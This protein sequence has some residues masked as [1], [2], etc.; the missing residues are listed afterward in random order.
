VNRRARGVCHSRR[1]RA[2][3]IRVPQD[4]CTRVDSKHVTTWLEAFLSSR[5]HLPADPGPGDGTLCLSIPTEQWHRFIRK[6]RCSKSKALRRLL[7]A[8]LRAV[9]GPSSEGSS[10]RS[11]ALANENSKADASSPQEMHPRFRER[12]GGLIWDERLA[13]SPL[14]QD[15]IFRARARTSR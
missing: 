1:R 4:W 3:T 9:Q 7:A 13:I 8:N 12:P 14:A 15:A 10:A 6:A 2:V 11:T 5:F